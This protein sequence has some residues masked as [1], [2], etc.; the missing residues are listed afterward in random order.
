MEG[1]FIYYWSEETGSWRLVKPAAPC[2]FKHIAQPTFKGFNKRFWVADA[3]VVPIT[4]G[5][6]RHPCHCRLVYVVN[7][8]RLIAWYY[9]QPIWHNSTVPCY[10]HWISS[11]QTVHKI[12]LTRLFHAQYAL[13]KTQMYTFYVRWCM[14]PSQLTTIAQDTEI[15]VTSLSNRSR[16]ADN[17]N[18]LKRTRTLCKWKT[19]LLVYMR[20]YGEMS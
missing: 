6:I 17:G 12:I 14:K 20:H 15:G 7:I 2:L 3:L 10:L 5:R 13:T 16:T 19:A 18:R 11:E 4:R 1:M 8:Q 9:L